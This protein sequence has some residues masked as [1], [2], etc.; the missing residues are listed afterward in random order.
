MINF[1]D[2]GLVMVEFNQLRHLRL[3]IE[4][5]RLVNAHKFIQLGLVVDCVRDFVFVF[6]RF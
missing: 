5:K 6:Q 2:W 4:C 1:N 3:L